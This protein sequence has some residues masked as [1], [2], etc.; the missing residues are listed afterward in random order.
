MKGSEWLKGCPESLVEAQQYILDH[1]DSWFSSAYAPIQVEHNGHHGTLSVAAHPCAIGNASDLVYVSVTAKTAQIIADRLHAI[2]PTTKIVDLIHT[3]AQQLQAPHTQPADPSDRASQGY[4][5][6]MSDKYAMERHSLD[7]QQSAPLKLSLTDNCGKH[8]VLANS[9]LSKPSGTAANYGWYDES[10]PYVSA[11]GYRMWQ[12]LGTRHND[13]HVDYSQVLQLVHED[14]E[15][16]GKVV[17]VRDVLADPEL[18]GMIS[19][20][21]VLKFLRYPVGSTPPIHT[22]PEALQDSRVL[23]LTSPRM[24]GEDVKDWQNFLLSEGYDLGTYGADGS[25]GGLTDGATRQFQSTNQDPL[26][27]KNLTVDGKVGKATIR[28]ANDVLGYYTGPRHTEPEPPRAQ[29]L[30]TDFKQARNY[31]KV[32]SPPR[33]IK[34]IV[35]HTAEIVEKP[36][37][38]EALAAWVSGPNAPRAS[39]HYC[40]DSDSIVQNVRDEDVAWHAPGANRNGIGI[41]HAGYARQSEAEWFDDFSKAT[42]LR[43]AKLV[44]HLCRKHGIP[45]Q[46]VDQNGLKQGQRGITTHHAVTLAF[47]QSTHTD[48]G[49]GFPMD[50]FLDRVRDEYS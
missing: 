4:S 12:T 42:L 34:W 7:N 38:A 45:I 44:A 16:D 17:K 46:Y 31:T 39:W 50:W 41:E 1:Q 20:E 2:L 40:V 30:V 9:L 3:C 14:M 36:T 26:T 27:G 24:T 22:D 15:V 32:Q 48:P 10:A 49:R 6:S 43:S 19:S 13:Q 28:S 8:W 23:Y 18:C 37:S 47:R 35:I 21:G 25:F 33:D 29:K 5:P 11:S